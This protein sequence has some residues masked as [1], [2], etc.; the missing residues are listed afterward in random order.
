MGSTP[1]PVPAHPSLRRVIERVVAVAVAGLLVV[2][3]VVHI[4][5]A[6]IYDANRTSALSQGTLF[7]VEA[8]LAIV[9]ALLV[10]AW[11]RRATWAAAILVAG[12]AAGAAV[13]YRYVNVGSVGPV[14][15]MYEPTWASPGKLPSVVAETAAALLSVV[16]L[17]LHVPA[18]THHR[19]L[20][21]H[22]VGAAN[23]RPTI[24]DSVRASEPTVDNLDRSTD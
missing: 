19:G 5:D 18:H 4:H 20:L 10:A 15:N 6:G 14:P 8:G 12:S 16:G 7:R 3:A 21:N 22:A 2:D 1:R 17:L 23:S 9:I 13:L 11:P 24:T